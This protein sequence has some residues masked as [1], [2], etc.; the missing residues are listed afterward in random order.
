MLPSH[1][2]PAIKHARPIPLFVLL[3]K[4]LSGDP[5]GLTSFRELTLQH[6]SGNKKAEDDANKDAEKKLDEIKGIGSKSGDKVV[7]ELLRL[8]TEVKPEAP[9]RV[10]G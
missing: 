1:N 3:P 2:V 8:V 6:S 9:Q 7:E 10:S 4:E 5:R